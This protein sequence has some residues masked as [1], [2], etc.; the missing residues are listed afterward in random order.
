MELRMVPVDRV[1]IVN[2]HGA[3]HDVGDVSELAAT[4]GGQ[5]TYGLVAGERGLAAAR[6][7][8]LSEVPCAVLALGRRQL[9][10]RLVTAVV[11]IRELEDELERHRETEL[12]IVRGV[13]SQ[14]RT[15]GRIRASTSART[16]GLGRPAAANRAGGVAAQV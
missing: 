8:G 5:P 4:E 7:A 2:G 3:R 14:L 13:D 15:V 9:A 10:K 12:R 1:R 16:R 11:R 6:Q